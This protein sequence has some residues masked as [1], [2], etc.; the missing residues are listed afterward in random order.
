VLKKKKKTTTP[1][2]DRGETN[3]CQLEENYD[4]SIFYPAQKALSPLQ[5]AS[6]SQKFTM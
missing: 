5:P 3:H 6:S 2:C 4:I 1:I